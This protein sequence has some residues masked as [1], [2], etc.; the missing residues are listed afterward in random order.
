M[1]TALSL[2]KFKR[3][4]CILAIPAALFFAGT[5]HAEN[6]TLE[7]G[8][9]LIDAEEFEQAR[10]VLLK[11]VDSEPENAQA[12]FLLC[13]VYLILGDHDN[14]IKH[15]KKAVKLDDS[16]SDYHLWLGRAHGRQ[17]QEGSK[18]KAIFRANR[19]RKEFEK[20]VA[21]DSASI[22]A[23]FDLAQYLVMAPGI[24]GGDKRKAEHHIEIL[25]EMD[26]LYGAIAW[27][28]Y[29]EAR[30]DT[31]KTES[32]LREASRLDTT[33]LHW[34]TY[35]WGYYLQRQRKYD[36]AVEVFENLLEK[37]PEET[38]ALYQI[39]RT[40]VFAEDSLDRAER[41]FKRYLEV[42][43]RKNTP[44]WAA[45]HWRLGMVYELKG[46]LDLAIAELEEALRLDPEN[47]E[48][49]KRLKTVQRKKREP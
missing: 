19:A 5:I 26:S 23:R 8:K 25:Q 36:Q 34:P 33:L 4:A 24:A 1:S 38:L 28:S 30:D 7:E 18:L 45:A 11:V 20:A 42:E 47:K 35:Q 44:D 32:Y 48:Y 22:Q 13:K 3:L 15:G 37:Y 12:N 31:S 41:C 39:G 17:A 14:S 21:L 16:V 6:F 2:A 46:E 29:W 40:Y 10:D 43:P 49:Q 9:S 27:A